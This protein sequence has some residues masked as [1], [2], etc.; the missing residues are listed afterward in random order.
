MWLPES[1]QGLPSQGRR[2]G[3]ILKIVYFFENI[4]ETMIGNVVITEVMLLCMSF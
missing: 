3:K 1:E 2:V 4:L